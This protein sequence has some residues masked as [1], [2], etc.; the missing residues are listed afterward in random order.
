MNL[1]RMCLVVSVIL[2]GSVAPAGA[3]EKL[4]DFISQYGYDWIIGKWLA[5]NENG[6][7]YELEYKWGLDKHIVLVDVKIGD[8][9]YHGMVM[10]VP[11]REEITQIGADNMGGT[12]KGTWD[13]DSEG[14]VNR[15][16]YLKADGTTSQ[17][18]HVYVKI[19]ANSF[20][21]KEYPVEAAGYRASNAR[22]EL[23]FKR[24]KPTE[25]Q[26]P[27]ENT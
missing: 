18:E 14:A 1:R 21:V 23:T 26:K 2:I 5:T 3:Q 7:T 15:N 22:G 16:E 27:K 6:R 17:I 19:D 12:W 10:F 20:K 11:S 9:E 24:Q 25:A 4:G 13:E 8:F